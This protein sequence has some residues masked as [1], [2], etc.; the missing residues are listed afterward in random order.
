MCVCVRL[1]HSLNINWCIS[2]AAEKTIKASR[3]GD[4]AIVAATN[5]YTYVL[6]MLTH[7]Q[8]QHTPHTQS[9]RDSKEINTYVYLYT[10]TYINSYSVLLTWRICSLTHT[11][12]HKMIH[13]VHTLNETSVHCIYATDLVTLRYTMAGLQWL[14]QEICSASAKTFESP[15]QDLP[16]HGNHH[17]QMLKTNTHKGL[18]LRSIHN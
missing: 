18:R 5:T 15:S 16:S 2:A 12:R 11:D 6:G 17:V 13:Y 4:D 1:S 14:I 9:C 10:Y 8:D 7:K 3:E